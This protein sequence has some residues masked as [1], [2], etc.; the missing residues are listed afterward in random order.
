MINLLPPSYKRELESELYWKIILNLEIF[1]FAFLIALTLILLAVKISCSGL[2]VAQQILTESEKKVI[3][4]EQKR[5]EFLGI[6]DLEGE[7]KKINTNLSKLNSFYQQ[8]VSPASI[9]ES[10][11]EILPLGSYLT[12]FSYRRDY[13]SSAGRYI[14]KI[15]ILGACPDRESLF[16][17]KKNLE[18]RENFK[19]IYFPSSNWLNPNNFTISLN[20]VARPSGSR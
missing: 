13:D 5:I 6:Q 3:G 16:Q 15:D 10:I 19:D 2:D 9:L 11:S 17:F 7:V 1:L 14:S 20:I 4:L 18:A 12:K 8:E